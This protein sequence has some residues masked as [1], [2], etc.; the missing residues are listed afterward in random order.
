MCGRVLET[1]CREASISLPTINP[2]PDELLAAYDAFGELP[3]IEA[4]PR[5]IMIRRAVAVGFYND[6][7]PLAEQFSLDVTLPAA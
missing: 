4:L 2:S 5:L 6:D 3:A 1:A 7:L